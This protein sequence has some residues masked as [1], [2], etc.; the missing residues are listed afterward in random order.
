MRNT[1]REWPFC[2][3]SAW[4]ECFLEKVDVAS[5]TNPEGLAIRRD[6]G[7]RIRDVAHGMESWT[8]RLESGFI[9]PKAR[10]FWQ[11]DWFAFLAKNE[12]NCPSVANNRESPVAA[13]LAGADAFC[14][15][16]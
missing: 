4:A 7:V 16:R 2:F 10:Q 6:R 5:L 13:N 3:L 14:G 11:T 12:G 9:T 15:H 1:T 8:E